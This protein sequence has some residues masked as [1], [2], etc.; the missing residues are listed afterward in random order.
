VRTDVTEPTTPAPEPT[1]TD[2]TTEPVESTNDSAEVAKPT[3]P[4]KA[5][6]HG[7]TDDGEGRVETQSF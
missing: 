2:P 4:A 7:S 6:K 5:A 1:P 3:P